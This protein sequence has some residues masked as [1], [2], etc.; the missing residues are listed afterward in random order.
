MLSRT[1]IRIES[2]VPYSVKNMHVSPMLAGILVN[3]NFPTD[4]VAIPARSKS[5][6]SCRLQ[7]IVCLN[8][9][10]KGYLLN[11]RHFIWLQN[12]LLGWIRSAHE[13]IAVGKRYIT[14]P[15]KCDLILRDLLQ[16]LL[17]LRVVH[18]DIRHDHTKCL[19]TNII[20]WRRSSQFCI[21]HRIA[22]T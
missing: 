21:A 22:K 3:K 16:I 11:N 5:L 20:V 8:R 18:G 1:N 12:S 13:A 7:N 9:H 6:R 4:F 14:F 17:H 10:R 19:V 15:Q 2:L